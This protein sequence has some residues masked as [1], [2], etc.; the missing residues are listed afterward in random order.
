MKNDNDNLNDFKPSVRGFTNPY[1]GNAERLEKKAE[2]ARISGEFFKEA[3]LAVNFGARLSRIK[4]LVSLANGFS[5]MVGAAG[6]EA[7][8]IA[9]NAEALAKS[10][11][12]KDL[13]SKQQKRELNEHVERN[14]R[15]QQDA[16]KQGNYRDPV[17][18]DPSIRYA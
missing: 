4:E 6:L 12:E 2:F 18:V 3:A 5:L 14:M 10:L 11:R 15:E 8:K 9:K 13:E 17:D 7:E 1:N 16:L